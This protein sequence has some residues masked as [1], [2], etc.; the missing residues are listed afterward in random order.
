MIKSFI[1]S[2]VPRSSPRDRIVKYVTDILSEKNNNNIRATIP[3]FDSPQRVIRKSTNEYYIPE[4][5]AVK[6]TQF[7]VF[8]VET[9]DSLK[10]GHPEDRWKLFAEFA[11]QNNALFYIVF[12]AGLVAIIKNKLEELNIEANLWQAPLR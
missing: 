10:Q 9:K 6:K 5:T 7:R 11:K 4:V 8:A 12:P 1:K 2:V 3:E